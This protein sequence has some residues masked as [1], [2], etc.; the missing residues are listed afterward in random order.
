MIELLKKL[1][2][3]KLAAAIAGALG[4]TVLIILL[5]MKLSDPPMSLLYN[6]LSSE[7]AALIS[8]RLD[9]MGEIYQASNGGKDFS[10]PIPKVLALRMKFAQE[11]IPHSG[12]IVGYEIF[13]KGDALGTSQFVY[14]VN[15][16]RALE[17]EIGRTIAS[18]SPIESVR[19]HLVIPKKEMFSKAATEPSA[20]VVLKIKGSQTLTKQEVAGISHII[21]TAVAGLKPE[22]IT[23]LDSS[24]RPLKL[25]NGDD[26][27]LVT[28]GAA[29]FQKSLEEKYQVMLESLIEKSVGVG[30]VKANVAAEINFDREVINSEIYDPE[31]QVVRSRKVSEENENDQE[32]KNALGVATN[33]PTS[34]G[35]GEGNA[36]KHNRSRTDEVTNYEI[37]KTITNKITESGRIKKLSIAILVDGT[38]TNKTSED[39]KTQ[40]FIYNPRAVEE[41][42]KLKVLAASAV[43]LDVKRGDK[44]E[45]INLQFSE[46]FSALPQQEKPFAW[47]RNKLDNIVQTIVIGLVIVLIMLLIVR[48]VINRLLESR[49]TTLEEKELEMRL[50][51]EALASEI[52]HANQSMQIEESEAEDEEEYLQKLLSPSKV[53][54]K[55]VNLIKYINEMVEKHPEETVA[56]IRAWLYSGK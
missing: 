51:G 1:G 6:N 38:Y 54:R 7:D 44:I 48:P 34:Q 39:G 11:G 24:G 53:D 45:V 25:A 22:R 21:A 5:S 31:S 26:A 43:G 14:N 46:E 36:S 55:K 9:A 33:V 52:E 4:I 16:I 10:V 41:M 8:A 47:L 37:S 12:N 49:A 42:D 29:D 27:D 28:E 15:F 50:S 30:K 56:T 23:I 19:V 35:G 17:G 20:S 32:G 3:T 18:L 13:D 2:P 40:E